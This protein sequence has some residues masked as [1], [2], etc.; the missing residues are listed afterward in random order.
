MLLSS[1]EDDV[2]IIELETIIKERDIVPNLERLT[3]KGVVY[4]SSNGELTTLPYCMHGDGFFALLQLLYSIKDAAG[5]VLLIE[6]P[7]N[8]MHPGYLSIFVEQLLEWAKELD[9]Q[10]FMTTHSY[11]LIEVLANY[12][13]HDDTES[14]EEKKM[15]QISRIVKY[16]GEHEIYNYTPDKAFEEMVTFKLDLRGT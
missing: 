4:K 7:E 13:M 2:K 6:E 9:I 10:V 12:S 1:F 14:A 3:E 11:D 15:I 16:Q 8:H 5:G